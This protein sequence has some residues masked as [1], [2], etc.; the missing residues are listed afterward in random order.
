MRLRKLSPALF[1]GRRTAPTMRGIRPEIIR[2]LGLASDEDLAALR[3]VLRNTV[4]RPAYQMALTAEGAMRFDL[5]GIAV[6]SVSERHRQRVQHALE[7]L[8][9]KAHAAGEY[10]R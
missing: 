7:K 1:A 10:G 9:R 5:D 8:R 6:A 3:A 4:A 2:R